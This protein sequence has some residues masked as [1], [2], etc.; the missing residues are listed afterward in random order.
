MKTRSL[1]TLLVAGLSF[2]HARAE[3]QPNALFS[4]N[5]VLQQN[6][7]VPVWGSAKEGEKVTVTFDGDTEATEAKDGQWMVHLKPHKP[8]GPFTLT[9]AGDNTITVNNVMVGEV[10]IC[11]GQSNMAFRFINA[12]NA[13][14][15][16]PTANYPNYRMFVVQR[17]PAFTPQTQ[18]AGSW[19]VCSPTTVQDFSAVGYFFGRDILKATG[20]P[21]GMIDSAFSGTAAD[22]WT[23]QSGLAKAPELH[24]YLDLLAKAQAKYDPAADAQYPQAMAD[25]EAKLKE[26]NDTTLKAYSDSIKAW[27]EENAKNKAA[28]LPLTPRPEPNPP[29]PRPP[30]EPVGKIPTGLFNGMIAPLIP[31]AIKGVVWY[32]GE[33]NNLKPFEYRTLFPILIADWREKWGIGDFPFIFVQIAPYKDD[34][35]ELRESQLLTWKSTDNTAMVVTTDVGD[36]VWIHPIQKE[37]VGVRL[38]LAA[39][40]LAYG[41]KIE[42]SGPEYDSFKVDG[43]KIILTFT[44]V[45]SG[46]VA[47]DGPLKGFEIAGA[48]KKFVEAKAEINGNTVVVSSDQVSAPV[49]ARYGWANVPDVNL[50]NKEGLPASIFRTDPE[51]LTADVPPSKKTAPA[52]ANAE[53]GGE[54]AAP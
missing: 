5:A 11:S 20:E 38:A 23:S 44:H 9:I 19:I 18:V 46:L 42:Y 31:Y 15:E 28:G 27:N 51:S 4:D 41:E 22:L 53:S 16:A 48:D 25:Y 8:G 7:I 3:V 33:S 43:N 54:P 34:I 35:P 10:W 6:T 2:S 50:W 13:K 49:A 37:P 29:K 14:E 40:A 24:G 30:M 39:R 47:K 32:Q 36:P 52:A 26:W 1:V 17:H 21:V 12:A 45:G